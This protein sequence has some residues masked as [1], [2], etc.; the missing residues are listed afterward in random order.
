MGEEWLSGCLE[1]VT[2]I[3]HGKGRLR[4]GGRVLKDRVVLSMAGRHEEGIR[5]EG[6]R[7]RSSKEMIKSKYLG[8]ESRRA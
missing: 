6:W 8:P 7:E 5:S 1:E 3:W 2:L 4:E